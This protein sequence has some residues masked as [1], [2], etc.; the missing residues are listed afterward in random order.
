M[1][2]TTA[3]KRKLGEKLTRWGFRGVTASV[4]AFF[5]LYFVNGLVAAEDTTSLARIRPAIQRF[6]DRGEIAGAVTVV[7][8]KDVI[9]SVEAVGQ[10]NI[11]K[12]APM[13]K[14]AIF[15]IASMT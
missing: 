9:L 8:G 13:T 6:V 2:K 5:A 14:N 12:Q 1:K 4:L 7:G 15:Q 11:E 10:M 3:P